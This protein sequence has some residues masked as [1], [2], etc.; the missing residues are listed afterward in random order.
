MKKIAVIGILFLFSLNAMA[1]EYKE[2]YS[3]NVPKVV[4][5]KTTAEPEKREIKNLTEYFKY[6][7]AEVH[8]HWT[9]YKASGD[10][11]VEVRFNV[12]RDGSITPPEIVRSTN[13]KAN[14]S[15]LN[16]VTAGAPY[17]PLP[18][19]YTRQSVVAQ[20]V[21]EFHK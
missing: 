4:K 9:P 19:T 12:N 2:E 10:Y 1:F 17:Q 20:I 3:T 16:A 13:E 8:R 6:L 7:P 18:K 5:N 21:L 15:V 11:E 14:T